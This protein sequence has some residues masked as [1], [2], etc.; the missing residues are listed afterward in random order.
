MQPET[1]ACPICVNQIPSHAI[2]SE[3]Y[4]NIYHIACP[5]CGD[6]KLYG[7]KMVSYFGLKDGKHKARPDLCIAVRQEFELSGQEVLISHE[8]LGK[9]KSQ[10][11]MPDNPEEYAQTVLKYMYP[12]AKS[13][14]EPVIISPQDYPLVY[15]KSLQELDRILNLTSNAGYIQDVKK[16]PD[17]AYEAK[18]TETGYTRIK[19]LQIPKKTLNRIELMELAIAEMRKSI[20]DPG[21]DSQNPKV[22]VVIA[23][24]DG[25]V[26]EKAHRGELRIGDHAEFTALERKSRNKDLSGCHVYTTLEPCA[27]GA[28][29]EPKL[30]CAE[31]IFNARIAKVIIGHTDPHPKV[32][33]K[34]IKFLEANGI[35]VDY[36]DTEL[37]EKIRR[38]NSVYFAYALEEQKAHKARELLPKPTILEKAITNKS[39]EDFS[40][41]LLTQYR[42]KAGLKYEVNSSKFYQHLEDIGV[43]E[44]KKRS[45]AY[46]PTGVG[47]LLFGLDPSSRFPQS[48]VKFTVFQEGN[49]PIIKDFEGS[50]LQIPGQ[51]E[52]FLDLNLPQMI[53]R[54][55]FER[56]DVYASLKSA[57]RETIINAIVHRDY[58]IVGAEIQIKLDRAVNKIIVESPGLPMVNIERFQQFNVPSVSRNP[59]MAYV[60]F[61]MRLIEERGLGL[62]ELKRLHDQGFSVEF[63]ADSNL[64]VTSISLQ[65]QTV[66]LESKLVK[67]KEE[68]RAVY[69]IIKNN[70]KLSSSQVAELTNLP[71]RSV[72]RYIETLENENLVYREG[73]GPATTYKVK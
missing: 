26:I 20:P 61:K 43:L 3:D 69:Q 34:G 17:G 70:E 73:K 31:R 60:F 36:F 71:I 47:Y 33:T 59:R 57:L 52:E 27:P 40:M 53:S 50:L 39:I 24:P 12:R 32:E 54:E 46:L 6:F 51:I 37:M 49:D 8:T 35:E 1:Q 56:S 44:Y 58:A 65:K 9:I 15:A 16:L 22:G 10:I 13:L 41:E 5:Y 62:R 63:K 48:R 66:L 19:A 11:N 28:R 38:E 21:R 45:D 29:H 23:S 2:Q 25:A 18:I 7:W 68:E 55:R 72:R 42:D 4:G 14:F 67:L 30:C 64:M